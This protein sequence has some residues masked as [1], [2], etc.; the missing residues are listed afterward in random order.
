MAGICRAYSLIDNLH[1]E[2][3]HDILATSNLLYQAW[4]DH[5]TTIGDGII[6]D[7]STDRWN[8]ETVAISHIGQS[9]SR[10]ILRIVNLG[11]DLLHS[12]E[13]EH[14]AQVQLLGEEFMVAS[15]VAFI[16]LIYRLGEIDIR[17]LR[18]GS[19]KVDGIYNRTI[20]SAD[21]VVIGD[22]CTTHL[23]SATFVG[24][25]F[26]VQTMAAILHQSQCCR[27]LE[28]RT[29][30]DTAFEG[31]VLLL[32]IDSATLL[33]LS[34]IH[35]RQQISRLHLHHHGCTPDSILSSHLTAQRGIGNM[36]NLHI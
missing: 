2:L 14:L 20:L 23:R 15:L 21:G 9:R 18:Y 31:V 26:I 13:A 17:R 19:P 16:I 35:Q 29:W 25:V 5:A 34:Q 6:Q 1:R 33:G 36:L 8:I 12:L 24:T 4:S 7:Q 22:K 28:C 3:L 27:Q 11:L 30:L 32:V 10:P